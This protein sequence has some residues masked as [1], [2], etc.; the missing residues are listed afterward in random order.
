[1]LHFG[2]EDRQGTREDVEL[3]VIKKEVHYQ[4]K[5][6]T[7]PK[8]AGLAAESTEWDANSAGTK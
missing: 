4:V 2:G 1:M 7:D 6:E 3:G 5:Y 8:A